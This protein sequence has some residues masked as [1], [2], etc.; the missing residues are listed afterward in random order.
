MLSGLLIYLILTAPW[1]IAVSRAND[2]FAQFFFVHEHFDRYLT[3]VHQRQHGLWYFVPV[4]IVGTV[5][6]LAIWSGAR[7]AVA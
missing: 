5:P 4:V 6:W 1:F 2:E 7:R 3:T